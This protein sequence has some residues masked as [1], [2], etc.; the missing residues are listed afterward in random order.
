MSPRAWAYLWFVILLG[1]VMAGVA[2]SL[3]PNYETNLGN[4]G[5]LLLLAVVAQHLEVK[6]GRHSYYPHF[7]PFFAGVVLLSPPEILLLVT[8]PH[9][10]EWISKRI[11]SEP[12][13]WYIQPFNISTHIVAALSSY[14]IY[15]LFAGSVTSTSFLHSIVAPVAAML[16]YAVINHLLIGQILVLARGISWAESEIMTPENLATDGLTMSTGYICAVLWTLNPWLLLPALAPFFIIRRALQV[17]ILERQAFT[18]PKTG[19]WNNSYFQQNLSSALAQAALFDK[20]LSLIMADMDL[21][22][23]VNNTYGHLAGDKVIQHIANLMKE[24][25]GERGLV[26][27]FGGEEF[28]VMLPETD[29]RRAVQVAEQIRKEI[30]DRATTIS[31]TLQINVTMSLGVATYPEDG[32]GPNDLIEQADIALYQAKLRGRNRVVSSR[33]VPHSERVMPPEKGQAKLGSD[34]TDPAGNPAES[35]HSDNDDGY[36]ERR[37][38]YSRAYAA[39]GQPEEAAPALLAEAHA[40]HLSSSEPEPALEAAGAGTQAEKSAGHGLTGRL[41]IYVGSI[42]GLGVLL[43]FTEIAPYTLDWLFD[44]GEFREDLVSVSAFSLLT[45]FVLALVTQYFQIEMY[46]KS[47]ISVSMSVIFA[48][49]A[50][51]GLMGAAVTSTGVVIVHHLSKRPAFYKTAFNWSVHMVAALGPAL[52]I[53][54][55]SHGG[56]LLNSGPELLWW[57][58][59]VIAAIL[60]YYLIETGL[61]AGAVGISERMSIVQVWRQQFRWLLPHYGVMAILGIFMAA[62]YAMVGALGVLVYCL[63]IFIMYFTQRDYVRHTEQSMRE[64]RRMNA[65][66]QGANQEIKRAKQGIEQVN[67]ELF[68][69][70]GRLIDARDPYVSNHAQMVGEYAGAVAKKMGLDSDEVKAIYRAGI[71]HDIGKIGVSETILHKPG[72]LTDEEYAQ[73]QAHPNLGADLLENVRSLSHLA[74]AIRYHHERWNGAGY[75]SQLKGEEIPLAA[76][77]LSVCDAVEAMASDRPYRRAMSSQKIV[78]ELE[79]N[80]GTQFDP[81]VVRLFVELIQEQPELIVNSARVVEEELERKSGIFVPSPLFSP[82]PAPTGV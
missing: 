34:A 41:R 60:F 13:V 61:V 43:L 21:L 36:E 66:M 51:H 45:F 48:A 16:T 75:P 17:P 53:H 30:A 46:E 62:A 18:D 31:D 71:L 10:A 70:L 5:I 19:L 42:I 39:T 37:N 81:N 55:Q 35:D 57:A 22:R 23:K 11:K 40:A 58:G 29:A 54:A 76:R 79:R 3:A 68:W 8:I 4:F 12:Y 14:Q 80:A 56:E 7:V 50:A 78:N 65:E 59:P 67:R 82:R 26:A 2:Y 6:Y 24:V 64:L 15:T 47:T 52:A 25:V 63:P 9:L 27:R 38:L 73:V 1:G 72:R 49:T 33:N 28:A 77:I 74:P 20:P 69:T 44:L 32:E